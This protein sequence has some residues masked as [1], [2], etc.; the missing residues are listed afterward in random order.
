M[1]AQQS[2]RTP[3][4]LLD[5]REA[6][7]AR[8]RQQYGS[9]NGDQPNAYPHFIGVFDTVASLSNPIALTALIL[10]A[11]FVTGIVSWGAW[12]VLR[13]FGYELGWWQLFVGL[14]ALV[15]FLS[16]VYIR[17]AA[18]ASR[19]ASRNILGIGLSI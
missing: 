12:L 14:T 17:P 13:F 18:F 16:V 7:A 9:A 15:G 1:G 10:L 5:Q 11:P 4:E 3:N 19:S 6:L 8:F 2:Y